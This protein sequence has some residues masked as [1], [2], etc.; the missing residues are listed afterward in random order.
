MRPWALRVNALVLR[1][2]WLTRQMDIIVYET[3]NKHKQTPYMVGIQTTG[4]I[5]LYL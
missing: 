3:S 5:T 4:L 1:C 2:V